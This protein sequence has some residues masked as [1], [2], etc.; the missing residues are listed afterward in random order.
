ML[1]DVRNSANRK[2]SR[3]KNAKNAANMRR[4]NGKGVKRKTGSAAS[5]KRKRTRNAGSNRRKDENRM[6]KDAKNRMLHLPFA[7]WCRSCVLQRQRL[8]TTLLVSLIKF[9]RKIRMSLVLK[10]IR[11]QRKQR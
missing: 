6:K 11:S 3:Q 5:D 1:V 8:S 9:K 7:K 10:E 4:T 2:L